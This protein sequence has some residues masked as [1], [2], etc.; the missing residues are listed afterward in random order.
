MRVEKVRVSEGEGGVRESLMPSG[1]LSSWTPTPAPSPRVPCRPPP[2]S[3]FPL[4][5]ILF[6]SLSSLVFLARARSSGPSAAW[7]S[8][9][10]I[11]DIIIPAPALRNSR[12]W[13]QVAG[14]AGAPARVTIGL[15]VLAR[16]CGVS[17][18]VAAAA[19]EAEARRLLPGRPP[20]NLLSRL[21][22]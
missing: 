9:F 21:Q 3:P 1:P 18:R 5:A 2:A 8:N 17:S 11:N 19:A 10:H 15:K 14:A 12:S 4:S 20:G 16:T 13:G 22:C 6:P 7:R